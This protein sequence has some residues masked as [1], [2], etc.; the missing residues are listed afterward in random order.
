M[1]CSATNVVVHLVLGLF[2]ILVVGMLC[3]ELSITEDIWYPLQIQDAIAQ[4]LSIE[5][6]LIGFSAVQLVLHFALFVMAC[7][8][9]NRTRRNRKKILHLMAAPGPADGRMYYNPPVQPPQGDVELIPAPRVSRHHQ[10]RNA[11][12]R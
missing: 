10:Q 12:Q 5:K 11:P 2:A 1:I 7:M 3:F 8:E 6:T 4:F 9:M